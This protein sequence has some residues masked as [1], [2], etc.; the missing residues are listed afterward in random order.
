MNENL[1]S[2]ADYICAIEQT[3]TFV[4]DPLLKRG[5][6]RRLADGS[7]RLYAGP[8]TRVFVIDNPE[9]DKVYALRCW[10]H[11]IGEAAHRY[12]AITKYFRSVQ[13]PYFVDFEYVVEGILVNDQRY[14]ILRMEWVEAPSL[15]EFIATYRH[16]RHALEAAADEFLAMARTLHARRIAH[17]DLQNDNIKVR[18]DGSRPR[19]VLIDYD[20]MFVPDLDGTP[21]SNVGVPAFQHPK[22][23][24]VAT[25]E[26]DYFAELVIYLTLIAIAEEPQLWEECRMAF[27][28]E[29]L[30]FGGEDF[31][32]DV[33]TVRFKRLRSLSPF[34]SKLTLLLWNYTRCHEIRWLMP[35]ERAAELCRVSD[36]LQSTEDS[37]KFQTATRPGIEGWL[38]ER[39]E[40]WI[41]PELPRFHLSSVQSTFDETLRSW[42][43]DL[44]QRLTLQDA[45]RLAAIASDYERLA[46]LL[47]RI[48]LMDRSHIELLRLPTVKAFRDALTTL[49]VYDP[50]RLAV[51]E[52][53][54]STSQAH[55]K[56]NTLW[57]AWIQR[58]QK[59]GLDGIRGVIEAWVSGQERQAEL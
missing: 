8:F 14:P 27:R 31:I 50:S 33:P 19:F 16:E 3:Q 5:S 9:K 56:P 46:V 7:I 29:E 25:A 40:D 22:R 10:T 43:P 41:Q 24:P 6:P 42:R 58:A 36:V 38:W 59:S 34:V 18:M 39:S 21:V 1:P 47:A 49:K 23:M 2:S 12:A 20:T 53:K 35:I 54:L 26:A 48:V 37:G 30:I 57:L 55:F 52:A 51:L 32:S 13:L 44:F 4:L 15:S 28:E 17:G 11:E 45:Q